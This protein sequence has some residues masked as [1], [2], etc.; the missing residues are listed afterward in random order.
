MAQPLR[1]PTAIRSP[2]ST[3]DLAQIVW[4][5]LFGDENAFPLTRAAA[6]QVP[7]V[8]RA[9]HLLVGNIARL[10]LRAVRLDTPVGPQPLWITRTDGAMSPWHRMA[11]TVDDCL[12]AGWSL[13]ACERDRRGAV[14]RV[15]RVPAEL[16]TWGNADDGD[17][18]AVVLVDGQK[19]DPDTVLLIPGPH[20][21]ILT[22]ARK[23]ILAA[24]LQELMWQRRVAAPIPAMEIHQTTDDEITDDE[25]DALLAGWVTAR[26]DPDGA[27]AYTP[28]NIE[29]KAHGTATTDLLIE[30]RN[31]VAVDIASHTGLP[32]AALNASLSTATLTY[33]TAETA[34]GE[35]T[36]AAALYANP[37]A[38]RL[39]MDDVV[40]RGQRTAFDLN[41]LTTQPPAPFGPTTED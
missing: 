7:A 33:S 18:G 12:F 22:S 41:F 24:R 13:W 31:A 14:Q 21:G 23:T 35:V 30:A 17:D 34:Q 9:R 1:P 5:D 36:A 25:I 15:E 16:W 10:P 4:A 6:I 38:A 26:T 27:V 19:V 40:P 29:L 28:Y 20:E 39:S 3:G 37:I 8:A 2:W 32:A 11:W